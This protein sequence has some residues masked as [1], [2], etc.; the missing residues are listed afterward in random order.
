MSET[1]LALQE[2]KSA[3]SDT[4]FRLSQIPNDI[5]RLQVEQDILMDYSWKLEKIL[6]KVDLAINTKELPND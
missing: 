2:I 4:K 6:D 1:E 3:L 5:K